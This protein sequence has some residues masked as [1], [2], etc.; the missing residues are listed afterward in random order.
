MEKNTSWH[1][2]RVVLPESAVAAL[3]TW[4]PSAAGMCQRQYQKCSYLSSQIDTNWPNSTQLF[5]P[6]LLEPYGNALS[7]IG[8]N[9]IG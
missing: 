9:Q 8:I 5:E 7:P 1:F 2:F 3:S 6:K 4:P